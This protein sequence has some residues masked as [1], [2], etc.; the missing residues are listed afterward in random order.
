[1]SSDFQLYWRG[2]GA[3]R[4]AVED[5]YPRCHLPVPAVHLLELPHVV[6]YTIDSLDE[7]ESAQIDDEW[8]FR[9]NFLAYFRL[10]S[11]TPLEIASALER[12]VLLG[13]ADFACDNDLESILL[14]NNES[15]VMQ[16]SAAGL[17]LYKSW[18]WRAEDVRPDCRD[19]II[20]VED[21]L[22]AG[23]ALTSNGGLMENVEDL[24]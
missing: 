24:P 15:P 4:A 23:P 18:G 10:S 17:R 9:P 11:A 3:V 1:M 22:E 13:A 14:F 21:E 6:A 16:H 19:R 8:A 12:N 2:V 5:L 20:L 7:E